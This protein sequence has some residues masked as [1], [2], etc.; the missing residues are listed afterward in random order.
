MKKYFGEYS[1][2]LKRKAKEL[3]KSVDW[4]VAEYQKLWD[5][6]PTLAEEEGSQMYGILAEWG[7]LGGRAT[8][9]FIETDGL[10]EHLVKIGAA[11][12]PRMFDVLKDEGYS[13]GMIH[14]CG[15]KAGAWLFLF[16]PKA[17]TL[18]ISDGKSL[19]VS[20]NAATRELDE[21]KPEF[22]IVFGLALYATCFPNAVREG[23]PDFAK[24][25][26]HYKGKHCSTI[27]LVPQIVEHDGPSPHFR[28]G[29]YRLLQSERFTN[30]RWQIV[31][32]RETFVQGKVKTVTEVEPKQRQAQ[33][34]L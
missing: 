24:H 3:G 28:N 12:D 8:H 2:W 34:S 22:R 27:G 30:K 18:V 13:L 10:A 1:Y 17:G 16:E 15:P 11:Y 29:H 19:T 25:P 9:Y 31:F 6:K 32:V 21:L 14:T 4:I 7:S 26:A 33:C 23:F 20:R 5:E